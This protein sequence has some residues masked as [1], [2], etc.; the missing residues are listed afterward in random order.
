MF[1]EARKAY[2]GRGW[3]NDLLADLY[4]GIDAVAWVEDDGAEDVQ[5]KR[6]RV[7]EW[8]GVAD[9]PCVV[10][11]AGETDVWRL[12]A[13]CGDWKKYL[14]TARDIVG[15]R[16]ER[17]G[18]ISRIDHLSVVELNREQAVLLVRLIAKHW[19]GYY[20]VNAEITAQGTQ[21]NE[22]YYRSWEIKTKWWWE[23]CEKL[24]LPVRGGFVEHVPLTICWLPDKK[25]KQGIGDL[26]PAV[27]LEVFKSD[28]DIVH[29]W[30]VS[31]VGLRQR[32]DQ[33]TIEEWKEFLSTRIP[34]LS[35]S[36]RAASDVGLR[37]K[38]IKWYE[39]CL[40]A[41]ADQENVPEKAF[42]AFPLLCRKGNS[43][44]YIYAGPRYLD[45]DNEFAKAFAGDAWL[46]HIPSRLTADAVKY[47][48]VPTLSKSVEVHVERGEPQTPLDTE[49][50]AKFND[51]LPYVWAWR[52][53]KSKQGAE[54]LSP[55]LK[56]LKVLVVPALKARLG[57]NGMAREVERRW[58]VSD[59]ILFLH[60]NHTNE[61]ELSQALAEAVGF[62][63][64]ADF[65]ENLLRC[66]SGDQRKEKLL[67]KGMSEAEVER[68]LREYSER[69]EAEEE[70]KGEQTKQGV[71][72]PPP[73]PPS[74]PGDERQRQE[75]GAS[76]QPGGL[77]VQPKEPTPAGKSFCLKDAGKVD[78]VV[79]SQLETG[80]DR[81][82]GGGGGVT[83]DHEAHA[84]P[85][86]EKMEVEE[87][88][89]RV[90]TRE[91]EKLGYAVEQM[92][93]ENPGFDLR[94][95]RGG[96]E[97]RVE[98]KGHTG[99]ATVADITKRQYKEYLGQ[100]GY[101]WEL[102]NV[103]HLAAQDVQQMVITRYDDIPDDA[104]DARTFLVN[105]KKCRSLVNSS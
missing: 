23:V 12:P 87:A 75:G 32:I 33:V 9:C 100:Q 66:D 99:R 64:E 62:K 34:A 2:F 22:R 81:I 13:N 83:P 42:A 47:F 86:K 96:E 105:L 1:A 20:R 25:T 91:L 46:F 50:L 51:S 101:R 38:T 88:G 3:G 84:L 70:G 61:A 27:D 82:G 14:E 21:G 95:R 6:R 39:A 89:R 17:I 53:S 78:Y 45:D 56:N 103:E 74:A 79:G 54:R 59:D 18:V 16:V 4:D 76:V 7:L 44:Q 97:L 30:L 71:E 31:A 69:P 68:C 52:S 48:G 73:L 77:P 28:K 35:P 90:A 11:E 8:L 94:G 15:R 41:L 60:E 19:D 85:E 5:G 63:S 10:K 102:W 26:L 104:L 98:V 57:L 55:R 49:S 80:A 24:T 93:V 65:Y 37:D 40:E 29:N 67:S 36:E 43:W 72:V 92:P 58:D